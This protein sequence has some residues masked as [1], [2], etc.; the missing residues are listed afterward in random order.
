MK[1]SLKAWFSVAR[2]N[3]LPLSI[4]LVFLGTAIA[5]YDG[6][7]TFLVLSWR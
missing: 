5:F 6:F 7:L 2:A 3:F 4:I 1:K